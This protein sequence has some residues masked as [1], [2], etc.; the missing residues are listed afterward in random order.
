MTTTLTLKL[1]KETPLARWY[2]DARGKRQWVPRSVCP[3]TTKMGDIHQ[4]KIED[5]WLAANP[6]EKKAAK[7]DELL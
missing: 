7:Q 4:V 5:W 6:F 1:I 3:H 2:E